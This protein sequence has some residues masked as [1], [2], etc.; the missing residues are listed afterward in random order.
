MDHIGMTIVMVKADGQAAMGEVVDGSPDTITV[1]GPPPYHTRVGFR[2]ADIVLLAPLIGQ[3]SFEIASFTPEKCYYLLTESSGLLHGTISA[4]QEKKG[5]VD[6][7][8]QRVPHG[9]AQS[10][11]AMDLGKIRAI[12]ECNGKP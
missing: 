6:V 2:R 7:A 12:A 3:N 1:K 11:L 9:P 5:S 4:H 8:L 10:S